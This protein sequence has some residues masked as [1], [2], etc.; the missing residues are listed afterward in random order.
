[1]W[2]LPWGVEQDGGTLGQE[3]TKTELRWGHS[4]RGRNGEDRGLRAGSRPG[5]WFQGHSPHAQA[6]RTGCSCPRGRAR[7]ASPETL[8]KHGRSE[9]WL[10]VNIE[11]TADHK[12]IIL[13]QKGLEILQSAVNRAPASQGECEDLKSKHM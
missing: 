9:N 7:C 8:A 4:G 2:G 1:M 11:M 12:R 5:T 10:K 6:S 3:E 13:T